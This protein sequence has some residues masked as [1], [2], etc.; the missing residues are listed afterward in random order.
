MFRAIPLRFPNRTNGLVYR[1]RLL[2]SLPPSLIIELTN[3]GNSSSTFNILPSNSSDAITQET[4]IA[5]NSKATDAELPI[6]AYFGEK[7]TTQLVL[8]KTLQ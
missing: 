7:L 8:C 2:K 4:V 6:I 3:N 1:A 5:K